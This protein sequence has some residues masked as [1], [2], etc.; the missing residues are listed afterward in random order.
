[1]H[2]T[3]LIPIQYL[4]E[5]IHIILQFIYTYHIIFFFFGIN[6]KTKATIA[7]YY[8]LFFLN[9]KYEFYLV[10]TYTIHM[11]NYFKL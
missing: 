2:P 8:G 9:L 10:D 7:H 1:M 5:T 3:L 6:N 4:W 11:R